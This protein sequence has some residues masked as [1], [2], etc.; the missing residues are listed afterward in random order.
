MQVQ[1]NISQYTQTNKHCRGKP[2]N[3]YKAYS[4]AVNR[5]KSLRYNGFWAILGDL[6]KNWDF[7]ALR[8]NAILGD[9]R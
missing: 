8:F 4:G 5:L 7:Q 9:L 2:I 6:R 3:N 1:L